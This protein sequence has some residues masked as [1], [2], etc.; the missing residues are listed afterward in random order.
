VISRQE[1]PTSREKTEPNLF[2]Q[3]GG[4]RKIRG[5]GHNAV[6]SQIGREL[7]NSHR[8]GEERGWERVEFNGNTEN[9]KSTLRKR[10]RL[11]D[12]RAD[13]KGEEDS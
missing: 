6:A 2:L 4:V 11:H 10:Q 8:I 9:R 3:F 12:R 5:V 13:E 1:N 7:E